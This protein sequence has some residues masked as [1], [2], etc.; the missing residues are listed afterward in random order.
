[1]PILHR[2]ADCRVLTQ[3]VRC[4]TH[5]TAYERARTQGKRERRPRVA[6]EDA[7]RA[8]T[9]ATHVAEYGWLCPGWQRPPHEV[10]EGEL[11]ADHVVAVAAGGREDGQLGVLCRSCN[12]S[13]QDR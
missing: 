6:A 12:S 13:K 5:A 3:G 4:P 2:C 7:R 8:Q 1:M 11:T 10:G 9:V